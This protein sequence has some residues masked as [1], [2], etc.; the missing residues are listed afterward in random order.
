MIKKLLIGIFF[1]KIAWAWGQN[2]FMQAINYP[3]QLSA[4]VLYDLFK[5]KQGQ[6]W[7]ASDKGLYRFNGKVA[8]LLPVLGS[9]QSDITHLKEDKYGR[10]WGMNFARQVF[11][12]EN[13]TLRPLPIKAQDFEG[14]IINFDFTENQ[15]WLGTSRGCVSY[16]LKTFEK[17]I[18]IKSDESYTDFISFQ[19]NFVG[20][21]QYLL[22][23]ANESGKYVLKNTP[24]LHESRLSKAGKYLL[25]VENKQVRRVGLKISPDLQETYFD[26]ALD[27]EIFLFH[28]RPYSDT[29]IAL[30]TKQGV[31]LLDIERF[32]VRSIIPEKQVTGFLKDYQGNFWLS[33][34][35]EGLWFCPSL[36]A[37]YFPFPEKIEFSLTS[38]YHYNNDLY[39]GSGEGYVYRIAKSNM[40]KWIKFER[41]G[42]NE[43]K[44]IIFNEQ[45]QSIWAGESIFDFS[46]KKIAS[47]LPFKDVKFLKQQGKTYFLA[48]FSYV[49]RWG[50]L[51]LDTLQNRFWAVDLD[52]NTS[53]R[54]QK[55]CYDIRK[56]RSYAVAIDTLTGKYWVGYND[57]LWEYDKNGNSKIIQTSQKKPILGNHLLFHRGYLVVG[58]L[59]Q[60]VFVFKNNELLAHFGENALKNTQ[61]RKLLLQD[62][63]IWIGT[64]IEIGFIDLEKLTF[65]DLLSNAGLAGISYKDF[66][67]D[68]QALWVGIS[69]G[70]IRL[71]FSLREEKNTLQIL[72]IRRL[73]QSEDEMIFE[74]EALN[75]QNPNGT[76]IHYRI[77]EIGE[78][79]K[80]IQDNKALIVYNYLPYGS[81]TLEVFAED[82]T[83]VIQTSLETFRFTIS[84]KWWQ[85]WWFWLLSSLAALTLI[86]G[87][88][89]LLFERYRKRRELQEALWIS[90]LKALHAQMNP[91]F[92]YNILYTIQ[93]LV[94]ANKKTEAGDLLGNFSD[95]MR[96]ILEAS[97]KMYIELEDE[98]NYLQL[99]LELEK[100]R[101]GD[102]FEYQIHQKVSNKHLLIP[103]MLVQPFVENALKH[104]LMH[105]K[106]AKKLEISLIEKEQVLEIWIEDNGI[107]REKAGLINAKHKRNAGFSTQATQKRIDILNKIGTYKINLEIFDKKDANN[108]PTGTLV[109]LFLSF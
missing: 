58:T 56:Q 101:L 2:P 102:D 48:A 27:R 94:Y 100:V 85:T 72:P 97:E 108:L 103:S 75:Y 18:S 63:K 45:D 20:V 99:Y 96:K 17:R 89:Y 37:L 11:Y 28:T 93:A 30:C 87:G 42:F 65:T 6:I 79:W 39:V 62:D 26:F 105:Q 84:R 67:V 15:I 38:I 16:D 49:A 33:T 57:N 70:I 98:V 95:L 81:Y 78:T 13:D 47:G 107:G 90:Q 40:K 44:K 69:K 73:L 41:E 92:L 24:L 74:A 106:G 43:I 9:L 19:N 4:Q 52:K 5:D 10:V 88:L 3:Y 60:G 86:G 21:T 54:E 53:I 8:H 12:V 34:L 68:T 31:Y 59:Q 76:Q 23:Y 66:C 14:T 91:H 104:G 77:R 46:G 7:I 109:K 80:N 50:K 83:L 36:Q 22:L 25:A 35:N 51:E 64:N 71:P 82:E 1:L 32:G 29:E 55:T 61:I